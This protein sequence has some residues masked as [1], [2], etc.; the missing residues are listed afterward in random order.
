MMA[1]RITFGIAAVAVLLA[2]CKEG[3][4]ASVG[5]GEGS[6]F[7]LSAE[8]LSS[9]FVA[10]W[11]AFED[12]AS[13]RRNLDSRYTVQNFSWS[14][15]GGNGPQHTSYSIANA[16]VEY[17]H[18]A[19]LTGAGQT[20]SIVDTGFLTSHDEFKGKDITVVGGQF[21]PGVDYH[22]TGVASI[23]AGTS[24]TGEMIGVAPG[25][26]LLLGSFNTLSSIA[27]ATRQADQIDAIVQNNSWGYSLSA[28]SSGFNAVFGS[29]SGASYLS[30][31]SDYAQDAVIV[32]AASND[33]SRSKI[34]L[35]A[36]LPLLRP[37]L[38]QSWLAVVNAVPDVKQGAI[39]SATL[40][41]SACLE[42]AAW[43][44]AADGTVYAADASGNSDYFYG[45]GTSFAAPQVSGAIA[46]LAEAFPDLSAQELRARLLA[47]A[48]NS[49]YDHT[50]V[51]EFGDG[52]LHGYD[53][54]FGHGFLDVRAALL[55]IGGS[56]M[57]TPA[58]GAISVNEPVLLAGG[59][60][61]DA[62]PQALSLQQFHVVDGMGGG[63][64]LAADA[65]TAQIMPVTA[66]E[67]VLSNL[68]GGG[69]EGLHAR[70]G[71]FGF[72]SG[73]AVQDIDLGEIRLSVL[74]PQ[75]EDGAAGISVQRQVPMATGELTL[76][77]AAL[78]EDGFLGMRAISDQGDLAATHTSASLMWDIP[79]A[80]GNALRLGG[81]VGQA[82][83]HGDL[84]AMQLSN[85]GYNALSMAYTAARAFGGAGSLRM[86]VAL[87]NAATAGAVDMMLPVA[88][89][90]GGT[91]FEETAV[92][93][94][95]D[96]RQVDLNL[97]YALPLAGAMGSEMLLGVTHSLNAGNIGGNDD[98]SVALAFRFSF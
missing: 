28:N 35:M 52:I 13:G 44:V 46:L 48:D 20:I 29:S 50:G 91:G 88:M 27:A 1:G 98:T 67:T 60:T 43:C 42:A 84:P 38:E 69:A 31:L 97:S 30:A 78:E 71:V 3:D 6:S 36:G 70:D 15:N 76:G 53:D 24:S 75:S 59:M 94:T 63:F 65:L 57:P 92:S 73:G 61:G 74:V 26:D 32:F 19:G 64:D 93:L 17:A 10:S 37:D 58:G 47:S 72:A 16:H 34:D 89:A 56:Y 51:V 12:E 87:P 7:A 79:L 22:G 18:A 40:L 80:G 2:G 54:T 82:K 33:G 41:S 90:A 4:L 68:I 96:A 95:P 5:S 23:A 77:L 55:P 49:F 81:S 39:Q 45:S 86:G 66:P 14:E 11:D 85:A 25:A 83:P 21:A 8:A 9:Y 62:L